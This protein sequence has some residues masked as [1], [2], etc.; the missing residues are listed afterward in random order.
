ML[1]LKIEKG[2]EYI[3]GWESKG[4]YNSKPIA[5]HDAFL[6]NVKYFGIK[7]RIQNNKTPLAIEQI[8]YTSGIVN[9]CIVYNLDNWQK[10][11]LRNLTQKSCLFGATNMI[12]NNDKEKYVY[13]GFGIAFDGKGE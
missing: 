7:I 13:S 9:V 4:L 2:T 10:N 11:L 6:S 3:V 12:K 8:N 5:L 1:E